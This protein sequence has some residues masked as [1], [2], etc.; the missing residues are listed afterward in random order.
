[1]DLRQTRL[2]LLD[3]SELSCRGAAGDWRGIGTLVE[4]GQWRLVGRANGEAC[5]AGDYESRAAKE[6]GP[7]K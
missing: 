2:E 4:I 5:Q 6:Q 3:G 1:M 7:D